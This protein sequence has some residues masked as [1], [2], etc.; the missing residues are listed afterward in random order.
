MAKRAREI[1]LKYFTNDAAAQKFDALL[2]N[3]QK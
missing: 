1:T 2:K 3:I